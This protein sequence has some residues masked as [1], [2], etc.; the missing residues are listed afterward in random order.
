MAIFI[1]SNS[2]Y[3]SYKDVGTGGGGKGGGWLGV[4]MAPSQPSDWGD[5]DTAYQEIL[6]RR[7]RPLYN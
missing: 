3:D 6:Q 1:R 5:Q 7:H 2:V 4:A